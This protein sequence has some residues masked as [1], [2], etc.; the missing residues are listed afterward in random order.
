MRLTKKI[1][2]GL[3]LSWAWGIRPFVVMR[4]KWLLW[5]AN[6]KI[7]PL[8]WLTPGQR[9]E[10]DLELFEDSD[11][12][13]L[14]KELLEELAKTRDGIF[15]R[16]RKQSIVSMLAFIFLA[17]DY[18]AIKIDFSIAGFSL[19]IAPGIKEGLLLVVNIIS[20]NTLMLQSNISAINAAIRHIIKRIFPEELHTLHALRYF[21]QEYYMP[22]HPFNLPHV[23]PTLITSKFAIYGF[24]IFSL[25]GI[26]TAAAISVL[27]IAIVIDMWL[28]PALGFWSQ[29]VCIYVATLSVGATFYTIITRFKLPY[30]DYSA[31][32]ELRIME[33][34]HPERLDA[35][36]AEIYKETSVVFGEMRER[37]LP[38]PIERDVK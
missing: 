17:A 27:N 29:A 35:R 34:F 11:N 4:F 22:Y 2:E 25:L 20:F 19:K 16:A 23:A 1:A 38:L 13:H 31:L 28:N 8:V 26:A 32:D 14:N 10:R 24:A 30:R 33:Q 9:L 37:G 18:F 6:N 5:R 15:D 7:H 3:K 21:A 12:K 36:R